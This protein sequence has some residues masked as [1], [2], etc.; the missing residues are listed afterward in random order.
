MSC[1]G[2]SGYFDPDTISTKGGT[3]SIDDTLKV[4]AG[5]DPFTAQEADD[6]ETNFENYKYVC[7]A[8]SFEWENP[9]EDVTEEDWF[10]DAVPMSTSMA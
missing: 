5:D 3:V 7:I 2:A 9:F 10:Y 6:V 1:I 4:K 8:P